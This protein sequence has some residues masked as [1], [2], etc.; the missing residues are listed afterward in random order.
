M[1]APGSLARREAAA[2][3]LEPRRRVSVKQATAIA[4][5]TSMFMGAMDNHIVNVAL[6]TLGREFHA[7]ASSV[8]WTVI[9]YVLS[10]AVFIPASGWIGDRLGTKRTFLI[11]LTLFTLS[12][13]L[14]GQA[15]NLD[16]LI[17]ARALQGA[18]G[19]MLVPVAT[20]M[21]WR[22]YPPAERARLA[23]TLMVPILV[24]PAAAPVLGGLLIQDLSWRWCFYVNIPVGAIAITIASR[25]LAEHT[26]RPDSRFDLPGFVLSAL[27]LSSLLYAISEGSLVGWGSGR[28]LGTGAAAIT[29]L[30]CFV[31]VELHR[32]DRAILRV[33]LLSNR[34]FR[35]TNVVTGLS[36]ASFLGILYLTPVFLQQARHQS[37]LGSGLTTFVEAIGVVIATQTLGRAYPLIGPRRMAAGGMLVLT[38][39][40][41]SMTLVGPST[42]QWTIRLVLFF[43][44]A[45]NSTSFLPMQT[46]MFTGIARTDTGHAAAIFNAQRQ[47]MLA[48]GVAILTTI[49]SSVGGD[50][51]PAFHAAYIAAAVIAGLG[52]LAAVTLVNDNDASATMVRRSRASAPAR[53]R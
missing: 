29:L 32:R 52:A 14:C 3:R 48:L 2:E 20:S 7:P 1:G 36:T 10:L 19:G 49:V 34:L 23:R 46:S 11:A 13:A 43:A 17:V 37:A 38:G 42:N 53:A 31:H 12:S 51:Y 40:I 22:A 8:Q 35:A 4:Y 50:S 28:V 5:V 41:A 18:G 26:E 21:M 27:G 45:A 39:L 44:G 25:Y 30:A 16:E 15:R 6:P 24:A 33:H 9:S 47:S